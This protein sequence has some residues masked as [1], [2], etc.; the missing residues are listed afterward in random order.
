MK[1][2]GEPRDIE[3]DTGVVTESGRPEDFSVVGD[4]IAPCALVTIRGVPQIL[5]PAGHDPDCRVLKIGYDER[6]HGKI[7]KESARLG[8]LTKSTQRW[9]LLRCAQGS[10]C[11]QHRGDEKWQNGLDTRLQL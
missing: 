3:V 4:E 5:I 10:G 8:L 2:S 7:R 6:F 9:H 1:S 11:K